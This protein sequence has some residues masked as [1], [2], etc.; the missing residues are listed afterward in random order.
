MAV[1]TT[2]FEKIAG[3]Y[4]QILRWFTWRIYVSQIYKGDHFSDRHY[5]QQI[6]TNKCWRSSTQVDDLRPLEVH[7][8]DVSRESSVGLFCNTAICV[9]FYVK[10]WKNVE[11]LSK[12]I[13][14]VKSLRAQNVKKH[15]Y[16]A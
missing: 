11:N 16:F 15:Q 9:F 12:N 10:T 3:F 4:L 2:L 13:E 1:L 5:R 6:W 7:F 8:I 14:N